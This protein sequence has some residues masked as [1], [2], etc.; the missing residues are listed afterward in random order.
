MVGRARHECGRRTRSCPV[1]RCR[2]CQGHFP[3]LGIIN[4]TTIVAMK[5]KR[6]SV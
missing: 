6:R 4:D 3:K 2:Y 5:L 1:L